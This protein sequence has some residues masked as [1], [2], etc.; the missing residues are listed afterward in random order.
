[1]PGLVA[2]GLVGLGL[3]PTCSLRSLPACP[4]DV[5]VLAH[6]KRAGLLAQPLGPFFVP[7]SRTLNDLEIK[8]VCLIF[9]NCAMY[10]GEVKCGQGNPPCVTHFHSYIRQHAPTSEWTVG[11]AR[12]LTMCSSGGSQK[13]RTHICTQMRMYES[14]S[15]AQGCEE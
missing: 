4:L 13:I 6:I 10:V 2:A 9:R 8:M 11:S 3:E 5:A 7:P 1:M 14:R 15:G 12:E